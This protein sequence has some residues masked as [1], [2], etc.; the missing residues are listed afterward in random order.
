MNTMTH[1]VDYLSSPIGLVEITATQQGIKSV[2]FVEVAGPVQVNPL[3]DQ[4][5]RQLADYFAGRL[6]EFDLPLSPDGTEFQN[7]VWEQLTHIPYGETCSYSHIA[8]QLD[9]PKAVRAVGAANGR[10][11]ISIIVP[12]HRV[13][14]AN[15][16]LT[17][18]AGGLERK[19][20]LLNLENP[21]S[22]I[23][24]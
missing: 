24:L 8:T 3:I 22:S 7:Q 5:K 20:W 6:M 16:T 4:A 18:Y 23:T 10:N 17:G 11:P 12:C 13:V 14:G 15:G 2:Y 21:Q 19:S 9:N 1:Y